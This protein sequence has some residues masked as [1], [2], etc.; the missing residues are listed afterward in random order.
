M[1]KKEL[2]VI[3]GA[4]VQYY[5]RITSLMDHGPVGRIEFGLAHPAFGGVFS[6]AG[7]YEHFADRFKLIVCETPQERRRIRHGYS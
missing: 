3:P 5:E 7:L 4:M 1:A 6:G 2:Y